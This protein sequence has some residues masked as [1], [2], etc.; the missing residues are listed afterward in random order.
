M[1]SREKRNEL[2]TEIN[3]IKARIGQLGIEI[4][5]RRNQI[6]SLKDN[7]SQE[8]DLNRLFSKE[9]S[10]LERRANRG[11]YGRGDDVGFAVG[12]TEY[13]LFNIQSKIDALYEEIENL[14]KEK[15]ELLTKK[16]R[17]YEQLQTN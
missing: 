14:Y 2:Y 6:D 4:G 7:R 9:N 11:N 8:R 17:L 3:V 15:N 5:R 10:R 12:N 16:T 13:A 1:L